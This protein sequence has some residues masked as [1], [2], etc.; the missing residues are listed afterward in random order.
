MENIDFFL[1]N[2]RYLNPYDKISDEEDLAGREEVVEDAKND[3][4]IITPGD[5]NVLENGSYVIKPE[6]V[7]SG[8]VEF[9]RR[10]GIPKAPSFKGDRPTAKKTGT[11]TWVDAAGNVIEGIRDPKTKVKFE[12]LDKIQPITEEEWNRRR[13]Q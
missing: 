12:E 13:N 7:R 8:I 11:G 6:V 10:R 3:G 4:I 1:K 2:L 5:V 9:L